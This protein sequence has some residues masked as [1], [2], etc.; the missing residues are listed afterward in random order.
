MFT[1]RDKFEIYTDRVSE[2]AE[3]FVVIKAG[4]INP[5]NE[6]PKDDRSPL[7]NA[8]TIHPKFLCN[9]LFINTK[10][11]ITKEYIIATEAPIPRPASKPSLKLVASDWMPINP[12]A[13]PPKIKETRAYAK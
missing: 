9:F 5:N 4:I 13:I 1:D 12:P 7:N 8:K 6:P 2:L 11:E 10:K 3:P